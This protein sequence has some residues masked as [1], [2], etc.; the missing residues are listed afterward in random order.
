[1]L[2]SG[3]ISKLRP[4]QPPKT[5]VHGNSVAASYLEAV[6]Q[7]EKK[8]AQIVAECK[9]N[10]IKYSDPHFDLDNMGD[11]IV[12][13]ATRT[14]RPEP[15]G[16]QVLP[17]TRIVFPNC[18]K[19]VGEI[20]DD[21][22]FYVGSGPSFSDTRQ[23]LEGDCWFISSLSSLCA[24]QNDPLLI[25][26]ICPVRARNEKVGVYGFVFHRDG[27]WFSE[28]IDDKLYMVRKSTRSFLTKS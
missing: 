10:N 21:P 22:K 5:E 11:S 24:G 1:M 28:V 4:Q 16:D 13:L 27:E 17:I 15:V 6:E 23:G 26:K 7:C 12:P 3:L 8:V 9:R 14:H 19:R 25:H 2:P 18:T 20:F